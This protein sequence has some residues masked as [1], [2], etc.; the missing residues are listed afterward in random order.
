M[1]S[2]SET[3]SLRRV[4]IVTGG[5]FIHDVYSSFLAPFLPLII[6]RSA[7]SMTL[8][9]FLSV[10]FRTSSLANPLLG[11]LVDRYDLRVFFAAAPAV[12]A[13]LMSSLGLATSYPLLCLMLLMAGVSASMYHVLGPVLIAQFSGERVGR[14]MSLWMVAGE[15]GRTV[16][17]VVATGAVGLFGFE[18]MWGIMIF[19]MGAS[20]FL[21]K[22]VREL[23]PIVHEHAQKE[24]LASTWKTLRRVMIPMMGLLGARAFLTG[25]LVGFL[26]TYMVMDKGYTLVMG[27][28][29]LAAFEL[30]GTIGSLAGGSLSDTLGRKK[31]LYTG[32]LLGP[33]SLFVFV[34]A[35]EW[36]VI[37]C[38]LCIGICVFACSP[39][40]LA[41]VQD[42]ADTKRGAANGFYMG[43]N[44][45]IN[46]LVLLLVGWGVDHFGF[47]L[48]LSGCAVASLASLPCIWWLPE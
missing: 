17:P 40:L 44:F 16:S 29:V 23:P 7:I 28:M 38:L 37:P 3:T 43:L 45:G 1:S 25:S 13:L 47:T 12:T 30:V 6:E 32:M 42:H 8:A 9:G 2:P 11:I 15:L 41:T 27:G 21:Y 5:H 10:C 19:G 26:P 20:L 24:S 33:A 18:G 34:H 14:G 4:M 48:T 35:S 36:A 31:V 46:S 39:V 22:E